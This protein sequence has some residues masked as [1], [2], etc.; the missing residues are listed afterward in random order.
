MLCMSVLTTQGD[1]ITP[2][3]LEPVTLK[4]VGAPVLSCYFRTL[5]LPWLQVDDLFMGP[6]VA[7]SFCVCLQLFCCR[8]SSLGATSV[9]AFSHVCPVPCTTDWHCSNCSDLRASSLVNPKWR[10]RLHR[11]GDHLFRCFAGSP[12]GSHYFLFFL[13]FC[14]S[15]FFSLGF[16]FLP[17]LF[18]VVFFP[19]RVLLPSAP[20]IAPTVCVHACVH[21]S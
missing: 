2:N 19:Q 21:V 3:H 9:A 4:T 13:F 6:S 15:G 18:S 1:P 12:P 17:L 14:I 8:A 7:L 5:P 11:R 16:S 20:P 10:S